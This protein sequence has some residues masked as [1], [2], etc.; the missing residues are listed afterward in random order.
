MSR[1]VVFAPPK[2]VGFITPESLLVITDIQFS[3][4]LTP[5]STKRLPCVELEK[6]VVAISPEIDL[7]NP[8]ALYVASSS[9]YVQPNCA[10]RQAASTW[11][12]EIGKRRYFGVCDIDPTENLVGTLSPGVMVHSTDP[13]SVSFESVEGQKMLVGL[14]KATKSVLARTGLGITQSDPYEVV[15]LGPNV[16][17]RSTRNKRHK[18]IYRNFLAFSIKQAAV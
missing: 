10:Q 1:P 2:S 9:G 8:D 6:L 14:D 18:A 15:E 7:D 13:L 17:H 16:Y 12:P 3:S 11:H 5:Y 4:D